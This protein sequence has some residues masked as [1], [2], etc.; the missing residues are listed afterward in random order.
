[1]VGVPG[2][3]VGAVQSDSGGGS[4][5][6]GQNSRGPGNGGGPPADAGPPG[7][8]GPPDHALANIPTHAAAWQ[9]HADRHAG[10]LNVQLGETSSGELALVLSDA[11]NHAGR[12][13]AISRDSLRQAVG[14]EPE[15]ANGLH[16]SGDRWMSPI[17]YEGEHAVFRVPKFSSNTVTFGGTIRLSGN[18][19]EDGA[20][21]QYDISDADAVSEFS[22]NITGVMH[23]EART[24]SGSSEAP[25]NES[26]NIG[27]NR[28]PTGPAGG[29]PEISVTGEKATTEDVLIGD[30]IPIDT[31][32]DENWSTTFSNPHP[33]QEIT[34][35]TLS[36]YDESSAD[37]TIWLTDE[38]GNSLSKRT[39]GDYSQVS[40]TLNGPE[41]FTGDTL[42]LTIEGHDGGVTGDQYTQLHADFAEST[43]SIN[44]STSSGETVDIGSPSDG[45][46]V[47]KPLPLSLSDDQL[48]FEG[49]GPL[50]WSLNLSEQTE[51]VDPTIEVNGHTASHS[52]TLAP[53]ASTS[54][55]VQ[56]DWITEGTNRINVTAT[57]PNAG[58]AGQIGLNYSHTATAN[59]SVTFNSETWSERYNVSKTWPS[60]R[61]NTSVTI[62]FQ[63][64]RIVAIRGLEV[65]R[66]GSS[67]TSLN[68]YELDGTK[69]TA[70]LGSV[71]GGETTEVRVTGRKVHIENGE[72]SVLD[73]TIDG[74]SLDT[75]FEIVNHS[76]GMNIEVGTTNESNLVHHSYDESWNTPNAYA[77][78]ESDG[79]QQVFLPNAPSGA[80]ARMATIP[81]EAQ[82]DSGDVEIQVESTGSEP[83]FSTRPGRS[84]PD[85]VE[86]VWYDTISSTTYELYDRGDDVVLDRDTAQS[87]VYLSGDDANR[88]LT[89]RTAD[90]SS[91]TGPIGNGGGAPVAAQPGGNSQLWIIAGALAVGLLGLLWLRRSDRSPV[92]GR[93][94][95]VAG[96]VSALTSPR[97]LSVLVLAGLA[98]AIRS[99]AVVIPQQAVATLLVLA[100][101]IVTYVGLRKLGQFSW[102]IFG[103]VTVLSAL[104][105]MELLSPGA[106]IPVIGSGLSRFVPILG[107]GLLWLVYQWLKAR[108]AEASTPDEVNR[109]NIGGGND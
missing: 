74:N 8:V 80:T 69:L 48:S 25:T 32:G 37:Y 64:S 13:V 33:G 54:L 81:L 14:H 55:D 93:S 82:L 95:P 45:E 59:Q 15:A 42:N 99:G 9:I 38:D 87:P 67:W 5:G 65:R 2:E 105:G 71:D 90:S 22:A 10:T 30:G 58:P 28:A 4:G 91:G 77:R 89:I 50:E 78:L 68:D 51:T 98:V 60:D 53:G 57:S 31:Y 96:L 97:G 73:P 7:D 88:T 52:G 107:L 23:S 103:V 29:N 3:Q 27:G 35:A 40:K 92:S 1:M 62:P 94:G 11:E 79:T 21:Y 106:I 12:E 102:G 75:K 36:S 47:S 85:A 41:T 72:I 17:R 61:V 56:A 49:S 108:R 39:S 83:V 66:N 19:A 84:S 44:V 104:F 20:Q 24:I 46:T 76:S 43:G 86:F 101:P 26:I 18:P 6:L 34:Q 109:I 70:N 100:V 16:E 63:S